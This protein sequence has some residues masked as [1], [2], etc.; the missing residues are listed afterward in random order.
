MARET[1]IQSKAHHHNQ[2]RASRAKRSSG[3]TPRQTSPL[4]ISAMRV[5]NSHLSYLQQPTSTSSSAVSTG[6]WRRES[7]S[8]IGRIVVIMV[9]NKTL[10]VMSRLPNFVCVFLVALLL[11]SGSPWLYVGGC[12]SSFTTP[13]PATTPIELSREESELFDWFRPVFRY[14]RLYVL[15]HQLSYRRK[16]VLHSLRTGSS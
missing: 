12:C 16:N 3:G 6:L 5:C 2:T 1:K 7:S 15:L 11:R 8:S 9:T 4:S 13:P 10:A 14:L